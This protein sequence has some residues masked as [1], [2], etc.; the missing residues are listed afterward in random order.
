MLPMGSYCAD[1]ASEAVWNSVVSVATEDRLCLR[2]T[3]FSTGGPV[4]C[5]CVAYHFVAE[6]LLL[7][8]VFTS[9][10]QHLQLTGAA[11]A[12]YKFDKLTCWCHVQSH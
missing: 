3:H 8:D 5:A 11:I 9:Q 4:L 7:L 2:A 12:G 6:A 1:V 10:K